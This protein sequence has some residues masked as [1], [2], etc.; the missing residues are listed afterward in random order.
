MCP[1]FNCANFAL[2][3]LVPQNEADQEVYEDRI[4]QLLFFLTFGEQAPCKSIAEAIKLPIR[5]R[6]AIAKLMSES[7]QKQKEEMD[8]ANRKSGS[9][10]SSMRTSY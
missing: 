8:R 4:N 2:S 5:Q 9:G 1:G 3:L 10:K 6:D 7:Y